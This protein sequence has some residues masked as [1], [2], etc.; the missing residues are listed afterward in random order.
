MHQND[1]RFAS[2]GGVTAPPNLPMADANNS[3]NTGFQLQFKS[4]KR[5]HT[6]L[7]LKKIRMFTPVTSD[8]LFLP[9]AE[10]DRVPPPRLC[11]GT[12]LPQK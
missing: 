3:G 11:Q 6:V 2:F 12:D 4:A 9:V 5:L 1:A 8:C 10:G 7:I